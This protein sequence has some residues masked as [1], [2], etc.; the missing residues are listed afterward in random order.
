MISSP[1]IFSF[2]NG[3]LFTVFRDNG[4]CCYFICYIDQTFE[5]RNVCLSAKQLVCARCNFFR[6]N[7]DR[8][9]YAAKNNLV[10]KLKVVGDKSQLR[11]FNFIA[12]TSGRKKTVN[13]KD[14]AS[15]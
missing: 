4:D 10:F 3:K 13:K 1:Q 7:L 2:L 6:L 5:R 9:F 12:A 15:D 8:R 14:K 11:F